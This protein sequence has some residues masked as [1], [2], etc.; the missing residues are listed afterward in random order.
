MKTEDEKIIKALAYLFKNADDLEETEWT[1][2]EYRKT[3]P[4]R[5][6]SN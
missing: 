2:E 4:D 3:Y 5:F 1:E 6:K